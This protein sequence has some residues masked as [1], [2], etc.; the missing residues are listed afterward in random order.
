MLRREQSLGFG[1]E[2]ISVVN[3]RLLLRKFGFRR[4]DIEFVAFDQRRQLLRPFAIEFDPV[5]MRSDLVLQTLHFSARF[6]DLRID[7]L[8][9]A[10]SGR[11][12]VFVFLD[13]AFGRALSFVEAHGR[14]ARALQFSLQRFELLAGMMR[15]EHLQVGQQRLIA[16]GF[17]GLSLEGADLAFDLF[18]DVAETQKIGL[19]CFEL[20]QGFAFLTLVFGNPGGFLEHRAPILGVRAEDLIDAALLHHRVGAPPDACIGEKAID[21][22]QP[23]NSFVEQIFREPIAIDAACN[24]NIVPVDA[25]LAGA[26]GECQ[27]NFRIAH[28]LARVGAVEDYVGHFP[29][30]QRLGRLFSEDPTD[31]VQNV[32]FSATVRTDNGSH[33]LVEVEDRFIGE[34][35]EPEKFE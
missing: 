16:A 15:I 12:F 34:R 14:Q 35:F 21:V 8:E 7:F 11:D 30:A 10:A 1:E 31:R 9:S 17:A 28:R 22:F 25:E 3:L 27:G 2:Q 23:A 13:L 4:S 18:D 26:I 24:A 33:A 5:P 20:A 19:R 6:V 29:S 32:R